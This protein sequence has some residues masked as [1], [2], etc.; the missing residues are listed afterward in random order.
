MNP[1][2]HAAVSLITGTLFGLFISP[3]RI[4]EVTAV[5]FLAG[6]LIDID[7]F[8]V[9]RLRHGDWRYLKTTFSSFW[10]SLHDVQSVVDDEENIDASERLF[11]HGIVMAV[12]SSAVSFT[13]S[14]LWEVAALSVSLH[15]L[16]DLYADNFAE[17][18]KMVKYIWEIFS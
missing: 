5:A 12:M 8:F 15:L 10:T 18:P 6:T 16:C 9:G 13:S 11:T 1:D 2:R 4:F 7:H 17:N 3:A 14:I